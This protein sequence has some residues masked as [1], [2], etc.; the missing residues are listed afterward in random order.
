MIKIKS[1]FVF[2]YYYLLVSTIKFFRLFLRVYPIALRSICPSF[3]FLCFGINSTSIIVCSKYTRTGRIFDV[4]ATYFSLLLYPSKTLNPTAKQ[5]H[6]FNTC[7]PPQVVTNIHTGWIMGVIQDTYLR[8][9]AAGDQYVGRVVA[10]LP[11]CSQKFGVIPPQI[12]CQVEF[13][14]QMVSLVFPT[15]PSYLSCAFRFLASSLIYHLQT[16]KKYVKDSNP[17]F[18]ASFFTSLEV[19]NMKKNQSVVSRD[20]DHRRINA[21]SLNPN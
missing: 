2:N 15:I 8:F 9:E 6:V 1:L 16:L 19:E 17:L 11:I 12:D 7:A 4:L 14:D 21:V 20:A 3:A 18:L 5:F 13:A 10:G